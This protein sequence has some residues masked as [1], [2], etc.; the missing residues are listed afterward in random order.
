MSTTE[1]SKASKLA[2]QYINNTNKH[3]FLTGKAGTGKT[4]FLKNIIQH[5]YKNTIIVAPTGIAAINAGGVTIHSQFQLPFGTFV[6]SNDFI[7]PPRLEGNI[8]IP[9]TLIQ[10]QQMGSI[11]RKA[12]RE[13]ELLIIDEVSMLRADILDAMDAVLRRIRRKNV[14]FGGLQI[15]FIGDLL[16]LPPV[17][18]QQEEQL[19]RPFYKSIFFFNALAL[20]D[21]PP[22]FIELD[23]IYRQSNPEFIAVLNNLRQ[24]ILTPNDKTLLNKY[25]REDYENISEEHYIFLTTHNQ[26]ASTINGKE[27]TK[28]KTPASHFDADI[29]GD[30]P[31]SMHPIDIRLTL[32]EGAQVMFIK[33]DYSGEKKFFNGKIGTV[34]SLSNDKIMVQFP[35]KSTE[36]EVE[37]YEWENKQFKLNEKTAEIEENVKGRFKHYPLRLAWAITI[38][39][40]QGLTFTKAIIDLQHTFAPGQ[41]YVALSRLTSLDGLILTRPIHNP[42]LRNDA[43]VSS[44]LSTREGKETVNERL[45]N[46]SKTYVFEENKKVFDFAYLGYSFN[47][48]IETFNSDAQRSSKQKDYQW[49]QDIQ[50]EVIEIMTIGIKFNG[51]IAKIAFQEDYKS[52][53]VKRVTDAQNYFEPLLTTITKKIAHKIEELKRV[54]GVK[55]YITELKD[56]EGI[57]QVKLQKVTQVTDF[58]KA[59]I[60]NEV[61]KKRITKFDTQINKDKS[62]P[63]HIITLQLFK[64]GLP[65][66]EIA[67]ERHLV[68][69]TIETHLAK[70][71][72]EDLIP[73]NRFISEKDIKKIIDATTS[74]ESTSL[75]ELHEHFGGNRYSYFKLRLAVGSINNK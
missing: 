14:P 52:H 42:N 72:E 69:T 35:D 47:K 49:A 73:R 6:P 37:A 11:K 68:P 25:V 8:H 19:L 9:R 29:S 20:K 60:N 31:D 33:N 75:S 24:N 53:L 26:K 67:K 58:S 56:L 4:T 46:E 64:G 23:K 7:I 3:I 5:T 44:Y 34:S 38:H 71:V 10:N 12:L 15:L 18:K 48:F 45:N 50:E 17:V 59:I 54:K 66:K 63:T 30:F 22:V 55:T 2:A 28:L 62:E 40:S 61:Y 43:S 27:L 32:K 36:V 57:I 21:N 1:E 70:C 16:Q 39:K 65:I 13:V 41:I 51:H 74:L